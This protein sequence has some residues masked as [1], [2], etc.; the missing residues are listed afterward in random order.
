MF[1]E[2]IRRAGLATPRG[3]LAEISAALWKGFAAGAIGE[4]E[5][6]GLAELIEARKAVPA[7]ARPAAS[8][9]RVGAR[10]R[11]S[12]SLGRRRAW[13]ASGWLPPAIAAGF[14]QAEQAAL[15]VILV[16]V[17]LKGRC[18]L[19][20]GAV[21]GRAG[22]SVSTVKRALGEARRLGLLS[23]EE[24]RVSWCRN[25]PNVVTVSSADLAA[26]V[27]TRGRG[28]L[29]AKGGGVHLG[30]ASKFN[31]L[32]SLRHSAAT[33]WKT[34]LSVKGAAR[35]VPDSS[36]PSSTIA[37]TRRSLGSI[38]HGVSI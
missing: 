32:D 38:R 22:V 12:A 20:H 8:R 5:A 35:G 24:R 33:A 30:T 27:R 13:S 23:V 31:D 6:Q 11:T 1:V 25:L 9:G 29:R 21:G 2:E 10:P 37:A 16:E 4:T 15:A 14:T 34:G 18:E 36:S 7:A 28:L 3:R 19:C 17:V 26:W